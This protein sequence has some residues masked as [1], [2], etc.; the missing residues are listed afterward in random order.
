MIGS[1]DINGRFFYS[2]DLKG[3]NF[4]RK[5]VTLSTAIEHLMINID[6]P[7]PHAIALL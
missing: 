7:K 3:V 1:P 5:S 4:I 2:D 6:K